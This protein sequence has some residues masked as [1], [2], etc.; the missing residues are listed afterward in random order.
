MSNQFRGA[1]IVTGAASGIGRAVCKCLARRGESVL[2]VDLGEEQ[3]SWTESLATVKPFVGDVSKSACNQAMV[4]S[5]LSQFGAVGS[6]VFN[7]A[8]FPGGD[9]LNTSLDDI[10]ALTSV[11]FHGVILGI[12]S[13]VPVMQKNQG[14]AICVTSS[15]GAVFADPSNPVYCATKA[16]VIQLVKSVAVDIGRSNV[17]VNAVCPGPTLTGPTNSTAFQQSGMLE[18]QT[19]LT[20][21][22]RWARPEEIANAIEFLISEKATFITGASVTVDGGW[23]A[24]QTALR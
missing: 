19:A 12:Q 2:A 17:R 24:G 10:E 15:C 13:V 22:G 8:V 5:A 4:E 11:N 14:G 21:L 7:A 9:I 18:L 20:P 6:A 16:A 3:L 1:T 23:T